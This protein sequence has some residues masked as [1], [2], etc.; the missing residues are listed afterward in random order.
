[1]FEPLVVFFA[2]LLLASL[3]PRRVK[4]E[5]DCSDSLFDVLPVPVLRIDADTMRLVAANEACA[6]KLDA[7]CIPGAPL[8]KLFGGEEQVEHFLRKAYRKHLPR[9]LKKTAAFRKSVTEEFSCT[10]NGMPGSSMR[11]LL[12]LF[13][14]EK[15]PGGNPMLSVSVDPNA[16]ISARSLRRCFD[17][18]PEMLFFK[19]AEGRFLLCNSSFT[20][21]TGLALEDITGRTVTELALTKPL[22]SLLSAHDEDVLESG[23]PFFSEMTALLDGGAN[24]CFEN[25]SYPDTA[26]DG[27][28][29][30]IFGMCRDITLSKATAAAL[31]R[32]GD[33]LQAAN[34]AALMLFSDEEDLDDLARRVLAIIGALTGADRAEV[35]RNHGSSADGLLCTQVY[36]WIHDN[37]PYYASSYAN[38]ALYSAHMPG[39]EEELSS[40]RS[41]NTLTRDLTEQERKHM[42]QQNMRSGLIVP[43]LFRSTFWGFI[44]LGMENG[45]HDWGRA[46]EATLRSVGLLLAA[47]MQRRRMLEALAESEQRFRDVTIAAGEIIWELDAQGYFSYVSERVFAVTGYMPE[48]VRGMR[49]EDF[50]IDEV[51]EETTGRMFQASVPTGSFRAFEHRIRGKNGN[52]IWFFTSGKLLTGPE[53]IA[54]LR[55]TSLDVSHDKQTSENLNTTLKAL[56]YANRELELSAERAH[57]LA[58]KAES[59]SQAKSEF[60]AN[61]SH[62]IRTPLNAIIGIAYLMKKTGLSRKQEDYVSKIHGA[63]VTLLG[64]VNDV[65]DFSKI[66][67]GKLAIEHLPFS[68]HD[69]F[70]NIASIVGEKAEEQGLDV[71]FSVERNVP[72]RLIGDPLR[73]GQIFINLVGNA[74]KFT[75]KGGISL[76]CLLEQHEGSHVR[77]RFIIQDTGI[78]IPEERQNLLFQSFS[79]IDSSITR[80]YGGSGL[81]LVI[82]K[83]LL[84]LSGGTL[85]LESSI[86]QGTKVTVQM[87]L[88]IDANALEAEIPDQS[89]PLVGLRVILVDPSDM[90]RAFILAMLRDMG[91]HVAAFSDIERGYAEVAALDG[92]PSRSRALIMPLSLVEE[93]NGRNM[94]R[95]RGMELENPPGVIAVAPFGYADP[96][97]GLNRQDDSNEPFAVINR[98]VLSFQLYGCLRTFVLGEQAA[99]PHDQ[100]KHASEPH[101][102]YF[103][104][105]KI[106]LVE[107]NNINQQIAVE[108]LREAGAS[109]DVAE[110]GRVALEMLCAAPGTRYDLV[111]MDLQ[112]PEMD[113]FTATRIIREEFSPEALPIIAMTAHATVDERLRCLEVGMNEHIAKPIDVAALYDTLRRWIKPRQEKQED[114]SEVSP[115]DDSPLP[116]LPAVE[117]EN[118]LVQHRGDVRSYKVSLLR[119]YLMHAGAEKVFL[120]ALEAMRVDKAIALVDSVRQGAAS[121]GARRLASVCRALSEDLA[122]GEP[123]TAGQPEDA[124]G[125]QTGSTVSLAGRYGGH[126]FIVELPATIGMLEFIF[127]S[128]PCSPINS[129]SQEDGRSMLQ[130]ELGALNFLLSEKDA[131]AGSVFEQL[132]PL[133]KDISEETAI[134]AAKALAHHDFGSALSVL[135]PLKMRLG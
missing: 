23:L 106:L 44:C 7:S 43:I 59:A 103:P 57:T 40:G 54:G 18:I 120:A 58:R 79:Q 94:R 27:V 109:V 81:G 46:E 84:D 1:M 132:R 118:A 37:S 115:I 4:A 32:Q 66:E 16:A 77:L 83:N 12:T 73:L 93:D 131:A 105:S 49:W 14:V 51:G 116:E 76:R 74:V 71:G 5:E 107:D 82:T 15:K 34:D 90:Q 11:V 70:E 95:L 6:R 135:K 111:F 104:Q 113:G 126:P 96:D 85:S 123:L 121:I 80:K 98:P 26:N 78:G 69:L 35:W 127:S 68:L 101:V 72:S 22:D 38:T 55:G 48:E 60:L 2:A 134:N 63:G 33:L 21:I 30:G 67:S 20:A 61:M 122:T 99:E 13:L 64:V 133:I 10:W 108:L 17:A 92:D 19:D 53:G 39:W 45:E 41:I 117:V 97:D 125:E 3:M 119:F 100:V 88:E 9:R 65:L 52:P 114:C 36:S 28:I 86:E 110:N 31:Q 25:H 47:T 91:C 124:S 128:P 24:V 87:P 29:R 112:M 56:E 129:A 130:A 102:P 8:K 42:E 62:E 50:A 75:E 89:G